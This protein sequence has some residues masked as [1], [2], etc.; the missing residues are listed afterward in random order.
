VSIPDAPERL[1]DVN[2]HA[3]TIMEGAMK[4]LCL[5]SYEEQTLD[6]LFK[7]EV[8]AL[9]TEAFV[10]AEVL[11]KSGHYLVSEVLQPVRTATTVRVW[12]SQV[13]GT[14]G[15]FTATKEQLGDFIL[16]D[17]RDL[18]DPMWAASSSTSKSPTRQIRVAMIRPQSER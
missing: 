6:A 10:Y 5:I 13:S 3:T 8:D 12:N 14:T 7:R 11:C 18:D 2:R 16:I 1:V 15:P 9:M 17:A 4:C